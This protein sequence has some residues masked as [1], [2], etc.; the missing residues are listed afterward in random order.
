MSETNN[1]TETMTHTTKQAMTQTD[2]W[3]AAQTMRVQGG[4]FDSAIGQ[5]Y[6][7][8]DLSNA[9]I[10]RFAFTG[11]FTQYHL[12]NQANDEAETWGDK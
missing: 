4:D 2:Y 9:A 11:L 3:R 8:A 5:A 6:L 7:H 10:M 12:I 1:A